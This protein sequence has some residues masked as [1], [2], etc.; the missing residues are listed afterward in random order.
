MI[1][2][3]RWWCPSV[4][5]FGDEVGPYLFK[6]ITGREPEYVSIGVRENEPHYCIVGSMIRECNENSIIWGAGYHLPSSCFRGKPLSIHAVRGPVTRR[7]LLR[8]GCDCPE[9]YG[10]PA[11]L[12]PRYY[13][14]PDRVM[15]GIG[16][17]PHYIDKTDPK[18]RMFQNHPNVRIIDIQQP[19]EKVI[20]EITS[21]NLV[22]SSSLHGIIAADAYNIPAF[23]YKLSNKITGGPYK[24]NDYFQSVNREMVVLDANRFSS[25]REVVQVAQSHEYTVNIDLDKLMNAC[26]FR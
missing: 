1:N 23:W 18:L 5:N 8:Q 19:V 13:S 6:H 4:R 17:I 12:L 20:D 11:L 3:L 25:V 9:V 10:D 14:P 22:F 2:R 16:M 7:Q 15:K 21:C 24:Y 26:P